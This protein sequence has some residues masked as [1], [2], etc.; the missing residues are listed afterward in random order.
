MVD[1]TA[2][3]AEAVVD[4][5]LITDTSYGQLTGSSGADLLYISAGDKVTDLKAQKSDGDVVVIV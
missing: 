1:K 5:A 4:E 2:D 3:G